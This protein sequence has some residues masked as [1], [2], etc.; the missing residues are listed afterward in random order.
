MSNKT[1]LAA[2]VISAASALVGAPVAHASTDCSPE[3]VTQTI[4]AADNA[5]SVYF[6]KYPQA[7]EVITQAYTQP[8]SVGAA[9]IK[10]YFGAHPQQDR[11]LQDIM[12][13]IDKKRQE[14][15]TA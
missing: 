12:A 8:E 11:E 10:A 2:L 4:R 13:P 15:K 5:L 7:N 6:A 9:N 1:I 3:S 14:C